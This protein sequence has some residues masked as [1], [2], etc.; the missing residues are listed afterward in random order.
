MKITS[1]PPIGSNLL[2]GRT[3]TNLLSYNRVDDRGATI[4]LPSICR[5][6]RFEYLMPCIV[7][8]IEDT[9]TVLCPLSIHSRRQCLEAE[10]TMGR[11]SWDRTKRRATATG[12]STGSTGAHRGL[13]VFVMSPAASR[14]NPRHWGGDWSFL[15][16][17]VIRWLVLA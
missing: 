14:C 3:Q 8:T 17:Y 10:W 12:S 6:V 2:C 5:T 11:F 15:R 9:M 16:I 13:S 1:K 7:A 4:R